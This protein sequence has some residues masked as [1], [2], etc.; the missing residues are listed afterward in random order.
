MR[1]PPT[2]LLQAAAQTAGTHGTD[3]VLLEVVGVD[4]VR[5]QLDAAADRLLAAHNQP[6]QRALAAPVGT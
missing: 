3:L 1:K 6:Q 5:P 2:G 4:V